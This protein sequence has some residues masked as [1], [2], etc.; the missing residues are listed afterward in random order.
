MSKTPTRILFVSHSFPPADRPL[1]N[2]GGMQRVAT[3]LYRTLDAHAEV[4]IEPLI[5]RSAWR[6]VHVR[7]GPFLARALWKIRQRLQAG[8]VDVVLFS[9]MVTASLAYFMR[10][11]K[12][13]LDIPMLAIVHGQDVTLPFA[14]YQWFVPRVFEALDTVLPVSKA[15][16]QACMVRGM[17][18]E[19]VTVVPNGVD[20]SRFGKPRNSNEARAELLEAVGCSNGQLQN[21]GLVLCSVGRHVER[22]GF[23]WF[24]D[25][26]MPLLPEDVHY[27]LAGIGPETEQVEAAVERRGLHDRVRVLGRVSEEKLRLL[28]RG[29]DLFV[30]P[31]IPVPGDMEGFGVVM[32]EA[33]TCGLPCVAARLEGICDVIKE[34]ANGHL[35][36]SE[37]PWAFSETIMQYYRHPQA[38]RQASRA[39]ARHINSTYSW[40]AIAA[41][42]VQIIESMAHS[43]ATVDLPSGDGAAV[44]SAPSDAVWPEEL[45]VES[46]S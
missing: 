5:M 8:D 28:Y 40:A 31:N 15:T 20:L 43:P 39:A 19:K 14:P 11:L 22:K 33:G 35:V 10:S 7:T 32:L 38:L 27:W 42:Y 25:Q 3:E 37:D 34:N 17:D 2:V 46:P 9:S 13:R 26:V 30:M 24:V 36:E 29:S 16:A 12:E 45:S 23:T 6:W 4:E 18:E 41:R 44:D 21:G 1:A